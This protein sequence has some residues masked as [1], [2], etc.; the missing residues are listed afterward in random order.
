MKTF[1]IQFIFPLGNDETEKRVESNKKRCSNC[2][3]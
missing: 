3:D 2:V 1:E